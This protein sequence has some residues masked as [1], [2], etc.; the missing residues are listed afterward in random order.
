MMLSKGFCGGIGIPLRKRGKKSK[1]NNNRKREE[2]G[3][4]FSPAQK[5][6]VC[7]AAPATILEGKTS[8]LAARKRGGGKRRVMH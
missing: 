2:R 3:P 1:K 8:V 4:Y 6:K 7:G 5:R